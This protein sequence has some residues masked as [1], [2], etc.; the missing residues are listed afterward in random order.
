M[1]GNIGKKDLRQREKDLFL[2]KKWIFDSDQPV[3]D[4]DRRGFSVL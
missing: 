4:S 2:C 1:F 3:H